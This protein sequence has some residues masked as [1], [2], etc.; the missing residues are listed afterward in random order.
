MLQV[1]KAIL[2]IRLVECHGRHRKAFMQVLIPGRGPLGG[3]TSPV[4]RNRLAF[5]STYGSFVSLVRI[6]Q[7]CLW[8]EIH[9]LSA[10]L[11][12]GSRAVRIAP[13]LAAVRPWVMAGLPLLA[14]RTRCQDSRTRVLCSMMSSPHLWVPGSLP[15]HTFALTWLGRQG[16]VSL[17]RDFPAS[18]DTTSCT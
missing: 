12:T 3:S 18:L 1:L 6:S 11:R 7:P 2:L 5:C 8:Q 10:K 4:K 13:N 9:L 15:V 16:N 14:V 17:C